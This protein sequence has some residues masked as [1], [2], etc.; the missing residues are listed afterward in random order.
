[1]SVDSAGGLLDRLFAAIV[2]MADRWSAR[3]VATAAV[4]VP[5][6]IAALVAINRGVLLGFA[7][8]G[9]EHAYLYQASTLAAGRLWNAAPPFPDSFT[10]NYIVFDGARAFSRFPLGWPLAIAAATTVGVP[11]WMIN[12][13]LG[14]ATLV[15]TGMLGARLYGPRVG[16]IAAGVVGVSPFFLFNG[17]SYFSHAFC[18]VLLL[19]AAYVASRPD[20]T[21]AWAPL[22]IGFLL[23]WAVLARY[24]TGVVCAIPILIWFIRSD[25]A[26]GGGPSIWR[27][28]ALV[29]LGGLPW[30]AV[31]AWHNVSF[32]GSPWQLTT[33]PL[34]R[35]LWFKSGWYY[36]GADII[37][38]HL[39][40]YATW[41]PPLIVALYVY[42]LRAA[43]REL[44]RGWLDWMLIVTVAAL[45]AYV[46]RG[47]NQYGPRFHYEV[48]SFLVIFVAA[49]VF[50]TASLM[51]RAH[52]RA[53]AALALSVAVL[54]LTFLFHAGTERRVIAERMGPYS[55]AERAGLQNAVVFM[56]GRVGTLRS[57]PVEDLTRNG[58]DY[59]G[60]V[61]YAVDRAPAVNCQ[62]AAALGRTPYAY[63]WDHQRAVSVLTRM[64]CEK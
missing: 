5:I 13:L 9:D 10:L 54:P 16:V 46:E 53:F 4:A 28:L 20:R 36:R 47:G 52:R 27:Q 43:P 35:S 42:Y 34:T 17:G 61:L 7:N 58:L 30:V 26:S 51:S 24:L 25:A 62:V 29:A 31:L 48:Y 2:R 56:W 39:Q 49:N 57:M 59:A 63:E 21:P 22:T 60:P 32:T 38:T 33:L 64:S 23:G 50:T 40:R 8:S 12:P 3:P 45:Y 6:V 41:T 37:S 19:G 11:A 55:T 14:A 18:G 15:L 1:M 44:R